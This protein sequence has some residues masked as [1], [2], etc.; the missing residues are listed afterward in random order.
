MFHSLFYLCWLVC[1]LFHNNGGSVLKRSADN[2][3]E[4][5]NY[6]QKKTSSILQ[7]KDTDGKYF[8]NFVFSSAII[9]EVWN[10]IH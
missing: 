4:R 2:L 3:R 8:N 5:V 7:N 10:C 1:C 6:Y 9:P